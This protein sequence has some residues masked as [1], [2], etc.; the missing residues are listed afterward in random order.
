M[1]KTMVKTDQAPVPVARYSQGLR[2]G[3]TLYVQGVI[4]LDPN[5]KKMIEGPIDVQT[6][7]IFISIK[8]ILEAGGMNMADVIKVTAF[9]ANLEDYP[10]FNAV[11]NRVFSADPPPVRTTVQA[12]PPLGALVEVEVI[13]AI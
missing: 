6:E 7:R 10:A 1:S 11:Y 12:R 8:A 2:I 3:N 4:A 5:T 13:A 9:L